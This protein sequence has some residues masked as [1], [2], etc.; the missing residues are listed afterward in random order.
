LPGLSSTWS[1]GKGVR[2]CGSASARV[3]GVAC[4]G[5][6]LGSGGAGAAGS[7]GRAGVWVRVMGEPPCGIAPWL[8]RR[9]ARG[10]LARNGA[11]QCD[12]HGAEHCDVPV[13]WTRGIGRDERAGRLRGYA[14]RV[15]VSAAEALTEVASRRGESTEPAG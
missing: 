11:G 13:L 2:S 6:S 8:A 3:R 1:I 14:H 4:G 10:V 12:V 7:S 5:T 9:E 15:P